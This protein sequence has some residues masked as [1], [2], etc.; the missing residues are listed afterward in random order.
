MH[1]QLKDPVDESFDPGKDLINYS[2]HNI[3]LAIHLS[4]IG[5]QR[6]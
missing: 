2:S 1:S 6:I 5:T 3:R 4:V